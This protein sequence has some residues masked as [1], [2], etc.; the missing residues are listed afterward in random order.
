MQQKQYDIGVLASF[1]HMIP[2]EVIDHCRNG[3]LLFHPS[4]LPKYWGASP[5]QW[6]LMD[7]ENQ[8]GCSICKM[9]KGKF[10]SG[11][12]IWLG[13]YHVKMY[14]SYDSISL[15]VSTLGGKLIDELLMRTEEELQNLILTV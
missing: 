15:A 12:L 5:I 1:G 4:T 10:D 14:D 3:I 2:D 11:P 9:G 13:R 6:A 8:I 7:G